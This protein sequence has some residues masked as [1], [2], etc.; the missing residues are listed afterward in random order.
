ML[1]GQQ[2]RSLKFYR[3]KTH[4][5][6][7][8]NTNISKVFRD[9]KGVQINKISG[10]HP[11]GNVGTQINIQGAPA[12]LSLHDKIMFLYYVWYTNEYKRAPTEASR[13]NKIMILYCFLYRNQ[14]PG[15]PCPGAPEEPS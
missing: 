7:D 11:A 14:Y 9:A 12:E 10:P 8:G 6:V 13:H 4:I 2:R 1:L 15:A 3:T 5:N